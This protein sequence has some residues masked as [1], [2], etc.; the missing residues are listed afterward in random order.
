MAAQQRRLA[1]VQP[2]ATRAGNNKRAW[3]SMAIYRLSAG[4]VKRSQGQSAVAA[5]AY[6][7]GEDL[8]DERLDKT[9]RYTKKQDVLKSEIMAESGA[10]D[11]VYE[12]EIMWN[13]FEAAERQWN[14]Q[15][16]REVVLSLPR[17]LS[18]SDNWNLARKFVRDEFVSKGMVADVNFHKPD[19]SDGKPNPHVHVLLTMR[20]IVDGEPN[21]KKERQWN[22]DF[23]DGGKSENDKI[24]GFKNNKGKGDGW[25][26]QDTEGLKGMRL[27]W[28]ESANGALAENGVDARIDN[29]SYKDQG[30]ELEPQKKIGI[31]AKGRR[32]RE[33]EYIAAANDNIADRN[34]VR[35]YFKPK[36]HTRRR[37][38]AAAGESRNVAQKEFMAFY[39]SE[40]NR[41]LSE[42]QGKG[43]HER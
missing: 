40:Q 38:S 13:R 42:L 39:D 34:E 24:G 25:V 6:R 12:R 4:I 17:E 22:R 33:Q 21:T 2:E 9:H 8:H 11:W 41:E 10:P 43:G 32:G 31:H 5:A 28:A 29:R 37:Q 1:R 30:I 36:N 23:T 27:R 18:D 7:A 20:R 15:P 3:D 26:G 16:A 19:A 35:K 14:G